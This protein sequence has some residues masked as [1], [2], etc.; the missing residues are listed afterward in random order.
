MEF[1]QSIEALLRS[2]SKTERQPSLISLST[3]FAKKVSEVMPEIV[4]VLKQLVTVIPGTELITPNTD[5][6]DCSYYVAAARIAA[7]PEA[8]FPY[9]SRVYFIVLPPEGVS[10]DVTSNVVRIARVV[11]IGPAT[12]GMSLRAFLRAWNAA[13]IGGI[14]VYE[15]TGGAS[16]VQTAC[17]EAVLRY[18][19]YRH[20]A[21]EM[22]ERS[23][24]PD[25]IILWPIDPNFQAVLC[26]TC[27]VPAVTPGTCAFCG[28]RYRPPKR[29][30]HLSFGESPDVAAAIDAAL[31]RRALVRFTIGDTIFRGVLIGK[32][33]NVVGIQLRSAPR[34]PKANEKAELTLEEGSTLYRYAAV[35]R[36]VE[37]EHNQL[38]AYLALFEG[39]RDGIWVI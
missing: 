36:R 2:N 28:S 6:G 10:D 30:Q 24:L 20:D 8:G 15:G 14:V 38:K 9:P 27:L 35:I 17:K 11:A 5:P 7:Y 18:L 21:M 39:D 16:G 32:N 26:T 29:A 25:R 34:I 37:R 1:H 23:R 12:R 19:E 22:Y 13:G 31:T 3:A 4:G 33:R